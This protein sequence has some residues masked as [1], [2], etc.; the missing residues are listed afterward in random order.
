MGVHRALS[1]ATRGR[2]DAGYG[3]E[4]GVKRAAGNLPT[5][6][7][8]HPNDNQP[9][10]L[11]LRVASLLG[12]VLRILGGERDREGNEVLFSVPYAES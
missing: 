6:A 4:M 3:E 1:L 10:G 2:H 7:L 11:P 8:L 5:L 12:V 9:R